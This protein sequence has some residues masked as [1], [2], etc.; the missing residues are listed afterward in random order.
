MC[1][2]ICKKFLNIGWVGIKNRDRPGPTKTKLIRDGRGDIQRVS[3]LDETTQ[4][5]EGMNSNGVSIISSSLYPVIHGDKGKHPSRDGKMIRD[6]LAQ[7]TVEDAVDYLKKVNI[8]GCVMIFDQQQLWLI[9]GKS[10]SQQQV[11]RL[12]T[13]SYI[14]RTNHGVWISSAGYQPHA[15]NPILHMRR[16]SSEA[17]LK[18][19]NY[20]GSRATEP[21]QL[22][23]LMA[24]QWTNNSQITTLRRPDSVIETRTTEQLLLEPYAHRIIVRNTDGVLDFDQKTANPPNSTIVVGII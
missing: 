12:I 6:A 11:A 1:T 2:L 4:W 8:H 10:G 9:E 23:T 20:I 21:N 5:S 15:S 13:N 3:L 14:A 16:I 17:R 22:M 19:G 7:A 24:K 18:I